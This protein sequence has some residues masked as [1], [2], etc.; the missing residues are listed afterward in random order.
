MQEKTG[1]LQTP[2][3]SEQLQRTRHDQFFNL[4]M[5]DADDDDDIVDMT[6]GAS[7]H[8]MQHA[9]PGSKESTGSGRNNDDGDDECDDYDDDDFE[10]DIE[11]EYDDDDY[12]EDD[13]HE[14]ADDLDEE[15]D[16]DFE[17]DIDEEGLKDVSNSP[18]KGTSATLQH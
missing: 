2:E 9:K 14:Q 1:R 13:W 11:D 6:V 7:P 15:Y 8:E 5:E 12:E 4:S 17:D 16:D 10:D 3:F 18:R